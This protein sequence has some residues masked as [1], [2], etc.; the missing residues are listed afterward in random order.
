MRDRTHA[1]DEP[2]PPILPDLADVSGASGPAAAPGERAEG[3]PRLSMR[4]QLALSVLWLSLNFQSAA[5]LPIVLPVQIALFVAPGSVGNV[6][7][8]TFLAWITAVGGGMSLLIPP[9]AG[10]LSDRT[11]GALGRRRPYIALGALLLAGGA[12]L[13]GAP[14]GVGA[15]LLGLLIFQLGSN[16]CTAGYQGL[17][18]DLV[19]LAQRGEASGYMGIMTILGNVGSLGLAAALLGQVSASPSAFPA[20]RQGA[21]TFYLLTGLVLVAGTAITLFGVHETPLAP[22][23]ATMMGGATP[24]GALARRIAAAW[25]GPWRHRNFAWVFLTRGSVMLGLSLFLTFIEY[26]FA[27]VE[28]LPNFV[29]Q[30]AAL[31]LVALLGAALSA[32]GFGQLS[33]RIGRVPL[34]CFATIC[35]ALAALA[36]VLVPRDL[37]LWPL[38]ILFGL[39]YGAYTSVDWALA[40]DALPSAAAAG[41][42][43]GLWAIATNLPALLAPLLG[44]GVLVLAARLGATALGYRAVFALA[45]LFLLAGAVFILRVRD[46]ATDAGAPD[47]RGAARRSVGRGWR[48]AFRTGAGRARGFLRFWPVWEVVTEVVTRPRPIPAAPH[49]LFRVEFARH[50]G[51]PI[52]LPDGTAVRRGDPIAVLHIA[53]RRMTAVAAETPTWEIMRMLAADLAA[54]ARWAADDPA[55]PAEVCALHGVTLLSRGARR[56]G[57]TTRPRTRTPHARL[58]RFFMMG[59][60]ALY[61]PRGVERLRTGTTY[62]AYPEEVW[63]S[64]D[65]LL[66]RYGR[67]NER[68]APAT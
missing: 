38:G 19:P 8:A 25:L 42:D 14:S 56:L 1:H 50:R 51:R 40:L 17:L 47:E 44:G 32:F 20:I 6:E 55:F 3:R 7:Q 41:K 53:N 2:D 15:L 68:D 39:G 28:E 26:Y 45:A 64:R 9:L 18:P 63:M 12:V 66:R 61:N 34:V 31:A 57:F 33:D 11:P 59:L 48:L 23:A 4:A 54:L 58:E 30:T 13:L 5:L 46:R 29:Q 60:L 35:M 52:A 21:A 67:A 24:R 10:A 65:L 37:P 27:N 22:G 43:M 49:G 62:G 16:V 36:F